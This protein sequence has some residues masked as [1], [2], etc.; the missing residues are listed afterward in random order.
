MVQQVR[1]QPNSC[2]EHQGS[3]L[4]TGFLNAGVQANFTMINNTRR[5]GQELLRLMA[6]SLSTF[7]SNNGLPED[8]QNNPAF[9][10]V[11]TMSAA[12]WLLQGLYILLHLALELTDLLLSHYIS[13]YESSDPEERSGT[14][15]SQP[16]VCLNSNVTSS[17]PSLSR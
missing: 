8:F 9:E 14:Q 3:P 11:Q 12:F 10:H 7:S 5:R 6:D 4:R 2:N 13:S 17:S 15:T 16:C 1:G